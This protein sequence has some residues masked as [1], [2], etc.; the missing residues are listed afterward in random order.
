[1][2]VF[3]KESKML[4]ILPQGMNP[5]AAD[6]GASWIQN[7]EKMQGSWQTRAGFG[8]IAI[9]DSQM[10]TGKEVVDGF[11]VGLQRHLGSHMLTNT[12]FGHK[13][14]ISI[15]RCRMSTPQTI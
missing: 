5:S 6:R 11:P 8:T 15:F 14:V 4:E 1:M 12:N 7:L 13:Q 3:T 2:A 9:L 10:T